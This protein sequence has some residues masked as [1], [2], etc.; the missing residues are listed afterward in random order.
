MA[1]SPSVDR[2]LIFARVLGWLR[3]SVMPRA[4]WHLLPV[5]IVLLASVGAQVVI[6]LQEPHAVTYSD[7]SEYLAIAR[8]LA[9]GDLT[10]DITRTPGYPAFLATIFALAGAER[11]DA[12]ALAQGLL[13]I[14]A[15]L[16]I[17]LLAYRLCGRRWEAALLAVLIGANL[18]IANWARVILA[19]ALTYWLLVTILFCFERYLR[20]PQTLTLVVM[21]LLWIAAIFTRH[22]LLYLPAVLVGVLAL[23]ATRQRRFAATWRPLALS[24]ALSYGIVLAYMGAF[25][26]TYG[27]F[28]L[29]KVSNVN[30]L[31]TAMVLH[32]RYHMPLDGAE[33][34]F[35][36]LRAD[37]LAFR[38][39]RPDPWGFIAAHPEYDTNAG[40]P[41]GTFAMQVLRAH[42]GYVARGAYD[43][44]LNTTSWNQAP[45]ALAPLDKLPVWLAPL[46]QLSTLI[47]LAYACLPLLVLATA[48]TAWRR[49][50]DATP[51][52]LF[53]L[54]VV[55]VAHIAVAVL[56]DFESFDRLRFPV[57]WA[58]LLVAGIAVV[59]LI[60][61][62]I[63]T[64]KP[65]DQASVSPR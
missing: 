45:A 2:P 33:S 8:R 56:A 62:Q 23:R 3:G 29:S 55:V 65:R 38:G 34:R 36:Q 53:A 49:Q 25:A 57:D 15:A 64:R 26:A 51:V 63:E 19:E 40:A 37:A 41:Y 39:G 4:R 59:A 28:G 24:L 12:V 22:Q 20:R 6:Q 46:L 21:T 58:M 30:L 44:F 50:D 61:G 47:S 11:L 5:G 43:A 14:L 32:A 17:Y 13:I 48:V 31:G 7:S 60:T 35:D 9:A 42:P 18:Y 16:E 54:M 27:S 1:L 10:P 52:T